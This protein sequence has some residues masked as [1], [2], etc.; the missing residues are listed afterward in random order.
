MD[1]EEIDRITHDV[2]PLTDNYPK[3]LTDAPWDDEASRGFALT[4]MQTLPALQRFLHSSLIGAIWP[5]S[6]NR[7]MESLFFVREARYLSETTGSNK[8]AELDLYL[9]HSRL[10]MPV[11]EVMGSDGFRLAIA[12]RVAKQAREPPLET[13][14]D[15]I[16]GALARRD[17][18]GAIRLLEYKKNRGAFSLKDTLL[19]TYLYCLNGSVDRA[20]A[21][22]ANNANS[23]KKD[24]LVDWLWEKL[25]TDFG[26]HPP[27]AY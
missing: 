11:L 3:R 12:E 17:F 15:L 22:A 4:Y 1:G 6:L 27:P 19:L 8:L 25:Q 18:N 5:E 9:R 16:A 7:S 24:W 21:L 23:I 14:P 20:E 26:F 10:R 13:G 2:A